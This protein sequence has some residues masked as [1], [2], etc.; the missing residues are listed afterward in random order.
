VVESFF[1]VERLLVLLIVEQLLV[2]KLLD[3]IGLR[4]S[5]PS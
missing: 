2:F 3:S 5:L 4:P 1:V